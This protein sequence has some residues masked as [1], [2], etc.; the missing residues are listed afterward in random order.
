MR[1]LQSRVLQVTAKYGEAA[2]MATTCCN[3]CRTCTTTNIATLAL[4]GIVAAGVGVARLAR[5]LV[6]AS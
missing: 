4:G 1:H 3:A 5:R 2:P 6:T